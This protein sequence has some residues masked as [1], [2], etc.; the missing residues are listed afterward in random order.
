M[1]LLKLSLNVLVVSDFFDLQS[2]ENFK[3]DP[4]AGLPVFQFL[5]FLVLMNLKLA[6]EFCLGVPVSGI[7]SNTVSIKNLKL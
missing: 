1:M 6:G 2:G 3:G 5:C 7:P 4:A